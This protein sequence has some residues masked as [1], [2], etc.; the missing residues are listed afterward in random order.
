MESTLKNIFKILICWLIILI[1]GFCIGSFSH[2]L[3][4]TNINFGAGNYTIDIGENMNKLINMTYNNSV[5]K[6]NGETNERPN[7]P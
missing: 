4:Q 2:P 1:I 3:V 7:T 5:C 6:E